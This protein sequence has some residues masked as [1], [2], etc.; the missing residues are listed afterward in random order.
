V[1]PGLPERLARA[2]SLLLVL[3]E[4]LPED[5]LEQLFLARRRG[6]EIDVLFHRFR[7]GAY[8]DALHRAG[9]RLF[10]TAIS[11][12]DTSAVFLDRRQGYALP[13]GPPIGD[14]FSRVYQLLWR[15]LGVAISVEGRVRTVEPHDS[16]VEL[17]GPRPVFLDIRGL[18]NPALIAEGRPI[19][20]LGVAA[21]V[22]LRGM[23][24]LLDSLYIEPSRGKPSIDPA[25]L[26]AAPSP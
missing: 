25:D 15:R 3:Q 13:D 22:G 2:E 23:A 1:I 16:L 7:D 4:R 24:L 11:K 8:L 20:A 6:A 19:R 12:D 17:E 14:G 10:E 9:M 5:V 26:R 18:E 21:F